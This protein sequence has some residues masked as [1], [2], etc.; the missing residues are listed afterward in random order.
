M[1]GQRGQRLNIALHT[2]VTT[3]ILPISL[4]NNGKFILAEVINTISDLELE[5]WR[6]GASPLSSCLEVSRGF[7][8][9]QFAHREVW[10]S[11]VWPWVP[12]TEHEACHWS[13]MRAP[14]DIF[15]NCSQSRKWDVRAGAD[16]KVF[17]AEKAEELRLTGLEWRKFCAY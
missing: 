11:T 16:V 8:A 9:E 12:Q 14:P 2:K 15:Q 1:E 7:A 6:M 5:G 10:R 13:C 4:W 3:M 17:I